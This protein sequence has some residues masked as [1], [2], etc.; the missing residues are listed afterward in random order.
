MTVAANDFPPFETGR[1]SYVTSWLAV[2]AVA[3]GT[4]VLVTSELLPIGL[5]PAIAG[6]V[7]LTEG[8]AGLMVAVPGL[9][10]AIAAPALVIMAGKI[11]RSVVL[12]IV[13]GLLILSNLIVGSATSASVLIAGRVLFGVSAGGFWAVG[14]A[15]AGRIVPKRWAGRAMSLVF[16]GASAGTIVGLPAGTWLGTL[17]GWRLVFLGAASLCALCLF[18]QLRLVPKLPPDAIVTC[19][20]LKNFFCGRLARLGLTAVALVVA[21]HFAAYTYVAPFLAR[22]A[23]VPTGSIPEI[24][25]ASGI[26]ALVG[27]G[28]TGELVPRHVRGVLIIHGTLLGISMLLLPILGSSPWGAATLIVAWG[29]AFGGVPLSLQAW[30]FKAAAE[31]PESGGAAFVAAFQLSIAVGS[32]LGGVAVD[33]AGIGACMVLGA[34]ASLAMAC[35]IFIWG[36]DARVQLP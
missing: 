12:S 19:D 36:N 34:L 29:F 33:N 11:D 5:L 7:H 30:T 26:A 23:H 9:T 35:V 6:D 31:S 15:I 21:G 20:T 3:L 17:H 8:R 25:L 4:F 27:N 28:I 24:L 13:T 32:Y 2:L 10:A 1:P 22:R 18:V 16:A 14:A